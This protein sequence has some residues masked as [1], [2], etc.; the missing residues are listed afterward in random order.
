MGFAGQAKMY[1]RFAG[2]LRQFLRT[3]FTL[4]QSRA[5]IQGRLAQREQNLLTLVRTAIY[6]NPRSPYRKLLQQAGCEYGD[7]EKL[8][9]SEGIEP[10]LTRLRNEGVYLSV[11]EFKGKKDVV[12][13]GQVFRLGDHDLDNPLIT[14]HLAG[15]SGG[16]RS[17]GTRTTFDLDYLALGRAV[18]TQFLLDLLGALDGPH[19]LW[20]P[21]TPG[22][23]PLEVLA[24]A[25]MGK[26]PSKWFSP[27]TSKSFRPS[28][29]CRLATNYIVRVGN[30]YGAKLP[31]PEYVPMD[32]AWRI[33]HWA[34]EAI[35][36][37][38]SCS[39]DAYTSNAVRI[40]QAAKKD[41]LDLTGA[42]FWPSGEPLTGT[43]RDRK[44]VV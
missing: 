16:S 44:S 37:H 22:F 42:K 5:I 3:P 34:S 29:A 39:I 27:V 8:V 35:K 23:G 4:E 40:C 9:R 21:I 13:G 38:G 41:G 1:A 10:A 11:E 43:K 2:H 25:K 12:R 31:A 6:E 32:E 24:C 14:P 17:A 18:Y 28:L 20:A 30:L 36:T 26:P 19:I 33:A 7:F 15:K